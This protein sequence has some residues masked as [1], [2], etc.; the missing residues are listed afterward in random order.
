MKKE[1]STTRH[2]SRFFVENQ[3]A[4]EIVHTLAR[5]A[6]EIILIFHSDALQSSNK[7]VTN[8]DIC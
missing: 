8:S 1:N 7:F 6:R 5:V 2:K 4:I 3:L